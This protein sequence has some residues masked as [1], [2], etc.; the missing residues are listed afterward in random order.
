MTT[1]DAL[2]RGRDA[3]A[4]QEWGDAFANLTAADQLAPLGVDDL[5]RLA[6]AAY[7]VARDDD[8]AQ[9]WARAHHEHVRLGAPARAARCAFWL[10]FGLLLRGEEARGSGWLARARRLLDDGRL[11]CVE[12]GYLLVPAAL[13]RSAEGDETAAYAAFDEAGGL[14]DRFGDPDLVAL[15]TLGRG[16]S[17][18]RLDETRRGVALLDEVMVAVTAGEVSPIIAGIVYCAV[19]E[20]FHEIFDLR[21]AQEWTAALAR[22]CASQ[23]DLVPYRGQCMVHR[24]E[25][26]QLHGAWSEAMAEAQRASERLSQPTPHP[27]AGL[28][29]YQ[30]GELHRLRGEYTRAEQAYRQ[31]NAS[32]RAPQ[33]G[34]V[35]LR[36]AQGQVA[37]AAAGIRRVVDEAQGRVARSQL[38]AA[39]VE[40]MLASDDVTAARAAADELARIAGDLGA[41]FLRAVSA[42]AT[43]SVLL[44]EGDARGAVAELRR[45]LTTWQE[46]DAPYEAARARV[47]LAVAC[48]RLGDPDTA[49]M[50][51]D[52]ARGVFERLGATPDA[53]LVEE[54]A[55]AAPGAAGGAG[56]LTARELQVL[57]LAAAGRTNRQIAADLVISEHTVRRHLQN[58]FAKLDVPS[59]AAATAYAYEHGLI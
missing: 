54:L 24:S 26:M 14:G 13:Q 23:P 56:G 42:H 7:L 50:E 33:P 40:I 2:D 15:A 8:S 39:Y 4:R 44:A 51:L 47:L 21:R 9:V 59:R 57:T 46:L 32:G 41:P 55:R 37:A 48:R 5:E 12:Q 25:I 17:L 34:L 38:L 31:A 52:A 16:Q 27:A 43:A 30:Q 35:R 19:I 20:A 36:L 10:G 1:A 6:M 29:F 58:I 53:A 28:A 11:D 3:F 18:L 45:S 49:A 22:W